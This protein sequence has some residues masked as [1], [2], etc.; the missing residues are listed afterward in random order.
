M[1]LQSTENERAEFEKYALAYS[2]LLDDPVR[3]RF[4]RDPLHFHWRKWILIERLLNRRRLKPQSLTWLDVGCGRG[5]LL[6]LAGD[7][8]DRAIGCDPSCGMLPSDSLFNVYQQPSPSELPFDDRS[9]DF[10]TAVCVLHHV[11]GTNR[12]AL[13]KE[14]RRVL[15]PAG[16]CCIV[17][18][19]PWNPVTRR[20]VKR[21]P[22][23]VDAELL[24]SRDVKDLV[25]GS[26][27][28]CLHLEYFLYL[29]ERAFR[30]FAAAE[31]LLGRLPLGGQYAVFGQAVER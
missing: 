5:E 9:I 27:F 28:R 15:R 10:A 4:T 26:G 14:I 7:R 17:E 29:P 18:H 11:H 31:F 19:N 6:A 30:K 20:I 3:N 16:L 22:V 21:C 8:F 23:D 1:A 24:S 12:Q 25:Q 13:M 2:Q